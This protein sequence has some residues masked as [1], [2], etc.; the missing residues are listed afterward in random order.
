MKNIDT[1]K[2]HKKP[3]YKCPDCPNRYITD[4]LLYRHVQSIH[5]ENIPEGVTIKQY[6][7]NRRNN[8]T[9]QVCVIC[10]KNNTAWNEK[11]GRYNLYCSE[12]CRKRAGEIAEENLKKKTGK[13]RK[14]RMND[15]DTQKDM[16]KNR[17]ISGT[18]TLRDGKTEIPYV[19]SYELD[20]LQFYDKEWE[21]DPLDIVE[22]SFVF[23]YIYEDKKHFYLP[24]FYIISLNLIIEIKDGGDNPNT[25]SHITVDREKDKQ[26]IQSVIED[27]RFNL[28]KIVN[29]DYV[30]FINSVNIIR[31]RNVSNEQFDPLIII[32]E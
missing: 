12:S 17:S 6:V 10:K 29:K 28:I 13:T 9:H 8:K 7:F 4:I 32:P 24:D 26:K 18:Y 27:G 31:E 22:C 1:I 2:R 14:E 25:H 20:F 19:G 3:K 15:P 23:N 16:L 30:H 21:G 11:S 5:K